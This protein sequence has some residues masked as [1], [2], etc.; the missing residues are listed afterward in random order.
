MALVQNHAR[1]KLRNGEVVISFGVHHLRTV[2]APLIAAET[3][4]D[5]LFVD[6]EHGVFTMQEATQ[7]CM[8]SLPAGIAGRARLRRRDRRRRHADSLGVTHREIRLGV[9][10]GKAPVRSGVKG[11]EFTA[12]VAAKIASRGQGRRNR[13]CRSRFGRIAAVGHNAEQTTT[14]LAA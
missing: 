11:T 7:L 2:A 6:M 14:G 5:I 8:A 9:I 4:H 12:L 1:R 13:P 10:C 3:G